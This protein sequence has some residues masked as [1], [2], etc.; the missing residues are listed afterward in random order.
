MKA[1]FVPA[2]GTPLDKDGNL[3]VESYKKQ[4]DDQ[5]K[6]GAVAIL[7]MGSMGQQPY[8][9]SG[10]CPKV[11]EAALEAAAGRVPVYVGAMD[12]GIHRAKERLAAME[13][14]DVAGFVFTTPYYYA[15]TREQMMN[16]FKSVAASTKHKVLLYDLAVVTQSKITYDMV[17]ELMHTVPNLAGMKS[18]D[19]VMFRKLK[20]NPDVPNDFIMV[21][22]G[23]DTFDIACKWGIDTCLD[24]MMSCTPANSEKL[25]AA[26]AA[27]DYSAAAGYLDN[28]TALRDFFVA[29]DLWPSFSVAMNLLGYDGNF[30]PDYVS[31]IKEQYIAEIRAEMLRIGEPVKD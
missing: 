20:L 21:Y 3:M 16:Y 23:L 10:V 22:S 19:L 25:F 27:G 2:L 13:H 12:C 7:C 5:I 18:A 1:G 26:I 24:G 8:L 4:I 17:L 29:R 6:A 31:P 9:R 30:A 11:A 15:C 14:L 28:I